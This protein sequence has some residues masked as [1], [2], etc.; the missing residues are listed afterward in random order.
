MKI[1][2]LQIKNRFKYSHTGFFARD[3]CYEIKFE[4]T[5]E[6]AAFG[7][8][9]LTLRGIGVYGARIVNMN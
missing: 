2:Q 7:G 8:I 9:S 3:I 1:I 5:R 6:T 4:R